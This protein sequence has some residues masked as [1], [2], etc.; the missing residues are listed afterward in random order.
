[1]NVAAARVTTRKL[2]PAPEAVPA[3]GVVGT[4]GADD[5]QDAEGADE[6]TAVSKE[7]FPSQKGAPEG[8][9]DALV[10]VL[11]LEFAENMAVVRF[12]GVSDGTREGRLVMQ[13]DR[14]TLSLQRGVS[15]LTAT[16]T[17]EPE[18]LV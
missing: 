3:I 14:T 17:A 8:A 10:V 13:A 16:C 18:R 7:L 12:V 9:D 11:E 2:I 15:V 1:M 5:V 6:G 4:G